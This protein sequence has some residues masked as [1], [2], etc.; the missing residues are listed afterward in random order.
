[1]LMVMGYS[2][3]VQGTLITIGTT[4][5]AAADYKIIYDDDNQLTWLDYATPVAS[6]DAQK[7]WASGL[8]AIG[9]LTYNFNTQE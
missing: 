7:S 2:I 6:W 9:V 3:K 4:T 1:M 8:N 5:Y